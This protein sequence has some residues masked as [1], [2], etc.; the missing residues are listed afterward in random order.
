MTYC[1]KCGKLNTE[2]T[3]YCMFCGNE[4]PSLAKKIN[5]FNGITIGAG[6]VLVLLGLFGWLGNDAAFQW[7][8]NFLI[9]NTS[10][11]GLSA[12]DFY[13]TQQLLELSSFS[14]FVPVGI[15]FLVM[16][17]LGEKGKI[18]NLRKS[19]PTT[20]DRVAGGLSG[21]GGALLGI[22]WFNFVSYYYLQRQEPYLIYYVYFPSAIIGFL[23]VTLGAYFWYKRQKILLKSEPKRVS[24]TKIL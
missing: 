1:P 22:S 21:G 24:H 18:T 3:N 19:K 12:S 6:I 20:L 2:K 8:Y 5:L 4:L 17:I 10:E 23:M 9:Q 15:V 7:I 14:L 16:G 11:Y 13:I